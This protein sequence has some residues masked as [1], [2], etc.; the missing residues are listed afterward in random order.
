MTTAKAALHSEAQKQ[1]AAEREA[2]L[3]QI[4]Q[5]AMSAKEPHNPGDA[6]NL[7]DVK[8]MAGSDVGY[9]GLPVLKSPA[10][11]WQIPMYLFAGGAAGCAGIIAAIAKLT[12]A[13]EKLVRDARW[14]AAIGGIVSPALLVGDL[15]YPSRFL[16]MLRV[17]KPKSP[18]SMGSWTLVAFTSSAAAAAFVSAVE[19]RPGAGLR[20]LVNAADLVTGVSGTVLAT[21][22]GVLIGATTI[23]VW[24]RNIGIL[25]IHF[26]ASGLSAA[27]SILELRGHRTMALNSIGIAACA[28]ETLIGAAIEL[29]KSRAN[30]PL[31]KGRTGMLTRIGGLLSGPVPLLLRILAGRSQSQRS[32]RLRRSAAVCSILGSLITR[33][34][35]LSA[36][37]VSATDPQLQL[38][39][40]TK[41]QTKL[42]D[43][44]L[45]MGAIGA[46]HAAA[47]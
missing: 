23:P 46:E 42:R 22:T 15:G 2:R 34:A 6:R 21:Y 30:E 9:Y 1:S 19:K 8:V 29:D 3:Q 10:W 33:K 14:V 27:T 38:T 17:F 26:A 24:N 28:T 35:W 12:V 43:S 13:E 31:R 18:M 7:G 11:T 4:R 20:V 45:Q 40:E 5:E 16:N 36:G 37:K 39:D 44:K 25:P 32:V 47:D 41:A